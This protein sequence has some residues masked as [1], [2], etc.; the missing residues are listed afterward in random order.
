M[1]TAQAAP[2]P[3]FRPQRTAAEQTL[4]SATPLSVAGEEGSLLARIADHDGAA[5]LQL[6]DRL[7]GP[8]RD[9]AYSVTHDR[10]VATLITSGV[11]RM[12]WR[13]PAAFVGDDLRV[14][15]PSLAEHRARQWLASTADPTATVLAD[16]T[17]PRLRCD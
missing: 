10:L 14:A 6:R 15:L 4:L 5:L 1:P 12:V 3:L 2:T 9:R 17:W 16:V 11:L 8:I 7:S 13:C